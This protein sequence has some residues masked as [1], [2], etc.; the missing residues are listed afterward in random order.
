MS[1]TGLWSERKHSMTGAAR[2]V[3]SH[4]MAQ[5]MTLYFCTQYHV[6]C[7]KTPF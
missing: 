3:D 5:K 7:A 6:L 1:F 2:I 4:Y